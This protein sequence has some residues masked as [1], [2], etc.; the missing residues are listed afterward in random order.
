MGLFYIHHRWLSFIRKGDHLKLLVATFILAMF[1]FR[2]GNAF[3]GE[4]SIWITQLSEQFA[5]SEVESFKFILT[6]F[7]IAMTA[8]KLSIAPA[9]LHFEPY[10]LWPVNKL[11]LS[12]QYV[13]LSHLKPAN[14]FWLFSEVVML[15]K[16]TELGLEVM[17]IFIAFWLMQH[18]L[19]IVLH[20]FK[21]TKWVI[22]SALLFLVAILYKGW[23]GLAW[24]SPVLQLTPIVSAVALIALISAV[25]FVKKRPEAYLRKQKLTSGR[26][27]LGGGEFTDPL[28]DLEVKL[29]W[30]NK[31]TRTNLIFG[32]L[33]IPVMLYYFGNAG[34]SIGVFFMAIIT[35]GLVLL[36]HGIYTM[37]WEG[38]YFDLLVTRFTAMEFIHFKF[39]FYFWA[40]FLGL[41][42][43][44]IA[45]LIDASYWLPLLAAFS[46][47]ITW[48]CFV[49]LNGVLGNKKKLALGQSIVF[50]SESMTANVLTV[51]FMS[52]IL[53]MLLLGVLSVILKGDLAYYG[54]IGVSVFGLLL[55]EQILKRIANR[56]ENKKYNLSMAFHD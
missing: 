45:L 17:S 23:L 4:L 43:S 20:P 44:S 54:V 13:L 40:T 35:T 37:S 9:P 48:N 19:N 28:F 32:F 15:V 31:G 10:R 1:V 38:N 26:L 41:I 39:R 2:L 22:S 30:R 50:K 6:V 56:M 16:A 46:Y 47:N 18:Y 29:I 25:L 3:L 53:P 14:F 34:E 27:A 51:S 21:S 42:F 33:A 5:I 24:V 49:V 12:V 36:Q 11:T 7:L 55:K 8:I 52:I